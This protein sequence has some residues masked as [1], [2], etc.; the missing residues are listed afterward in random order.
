MAA[1]LA[2]ALSGCGSVMEPE[3]ADPQAADTWR[4]EMVRSTVPDDPAEVRFAGV[5]D[6]D[7]QLGRLLITDDEE[8]WAYTKCEV[9]TSRI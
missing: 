5:F 8:A 4:F 1:A 9:E 3:A 2:F 7:R 6:H